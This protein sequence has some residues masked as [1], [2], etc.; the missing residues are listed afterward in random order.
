MTRW[1]KIKERPRDGGNRP[2]LR[3]TV[4]ESTC[5]ILDLARAAVSAPDETPGRTALHVRPRLIVNGGQR[6]VGPANM[7]LSDSRAA[8][9]VSQRTAGGDPSATPVTSISRL[10][11]AHAAEISRANGTTTARHAS[12]TKSIDTGTELR[13]PTLTSYEP[14]STGVVQSV[15]SRRSPCFA[16]T[17]TMRPARFE[18]SSARSAIRE[19]GSS[20]TTQHGW[21][22]RPGTCGYNRGGAR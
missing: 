7:R 18:G 2:G 20:T 21:S 14:L 1:S 22:L 13:Q 15:E 9:V 3:P 16:S 19:S 6:P 8:G 17:T 10:T 5:L 11:A 12:G 4:L